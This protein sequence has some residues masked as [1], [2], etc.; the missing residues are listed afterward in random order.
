M[1]IVS[2]ERIKRQAIS[3]RPRTTFLEKIE[4]CPKRP[5]CRGNV[6]ERVCV[7]ECVCVFAHLCMHIHTLWPFR[8]RMAQASMGRSDFVHNARLLIPLKRWAPVVLPHK[9]N[10]TIPESTS[11]DKLFHLFSIS[12]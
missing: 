5:G 12:K 3:Y 9:I 6:C 11:S 2:S 8:D 10:D 4:G 7:C 1:S